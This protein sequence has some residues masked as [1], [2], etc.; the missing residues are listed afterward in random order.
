V[1]QRTRLFF[2]AA[3]LKIGG[4]IACNIFAVSTADWN[5]KNV[6]RTCTD[7]LRTIKYVSLGQWF[8]SCI[9]IVLL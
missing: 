6:M 1:I 7:A 5:D 9:A 8:Y 4:N 3:L 2:R